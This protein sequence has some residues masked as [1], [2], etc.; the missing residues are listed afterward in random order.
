[1]SRH[2][3]LLENLNGRLRLKPACPDSHTNIPHISNVKRNLM[4]SRVLHIKG[5]RDLNLQF[6]H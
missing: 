1:M 2:H 4:Y 5:G 3:G 6:F